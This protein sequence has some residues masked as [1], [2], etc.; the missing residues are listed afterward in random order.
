M[1]RADTLATP[2]RS[3]GR[4]STGDRRTRF[5]RHTIVTTQIA[6][7]VFLLVGAG[8]LI[9][10]FVRLQDR[11]FGFRTE[12][13]MTAQLVLPRDRF[14]TPAETG[15][16][17]NQLLSGIAA[18][19]GVES[20]GVINTLPLTGFNALRPYNRPGRPPEERF[21]EFRIVS[22]GYFKTMD[23]AL[24]SGRVF[25][26]RDRLGAM[27]VTVINESAARRLWP[28]ENPV[29]QTLMVSD[30]MN[31]KPMTVIGVVGDTR[32]H[33]LARDPE[34]EIY[35][36]ADQT[37]WP[38]FGLVVRSHVAPESL[39]RSI[40]AVGATIDRNVPLSAFKAMDDLAST[41][42][43]WRRSSM[44]LLSLFAGAAALLA[45]VG[46]YSVMAHN[47]SARSREIGVRLALGARPADI[48]R[49]VVSQGAAL[50]FTGT[51]VGLVLSA[52][53]GSVLGALLFGVQ[54]IDALTFS[55][56]T[57]IAVIAGM[58]ATGVPAITAAR[59]DPTVALRGE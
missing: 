3:S 30:F 40:R 53:I 39:E 44:A 32:H 17:L 31:P 7:S 15:Q 59:V 34:V 26:H 50:T 51:L 14:A 41:T 37:Y 47:V 49:A 4:G 57:I 22:P 54:A 5:L 1:R 52:L 21:A 13:V 43:A 20:T 55:A 19:P 48:A 46:V 8:L 38:F 56:V 28:G 16:F 29:G 10:S 9:R 6:L 58:L 45:F 23:I 24:R 18:L 11:S 2:L 36:P 27:D 33:D 12:D 42:W 35:R 25:E